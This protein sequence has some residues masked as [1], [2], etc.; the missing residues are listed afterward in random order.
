MKRLT[1]V[2]SRN[3]DVDSGRRQEAFE[4]WIWKGME[5]M[6]WLDKVST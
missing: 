2:R 3:M 1:S 6:S 5:N 4:M